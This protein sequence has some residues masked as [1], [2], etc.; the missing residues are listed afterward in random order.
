MGGGFPSFRVSKFPSNWVSEFLSFRVTEFPS[1]QVSKGGREWG[2]MRGLELIM[3]SQGQWEA[4][5]KTAPDGTNRQTSGH[6]ESP[7]AT[8][9]PTRPSWWNISLISLSIF[10]G[11]HTF[12]KMDLF[13]ILLACLAYP[14]T[15]VV[16]FSIY[17]LAEACLKSRT[18]DR[19]EEEEL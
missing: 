3:W 12:L 18:E 10:S 5:E 2:P 19:S 4:S 1:F 13:L 16:T 11:Q 9:W 14:T 6:G 15:V 8:L 7:L 17:K